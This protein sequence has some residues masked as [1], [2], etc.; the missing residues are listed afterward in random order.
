MTDVRVIPCLLLKNTG[1]VKTTRFADPVY[2]G[3]VINVVKLFNDMEADELGILDVTA[4]R[5]G[6][7]PSFGLLAKVA[8]NAFMP[9]SYGGG[10]ADL[11]DIHKILALGF[12][13]VII[14]SRAV[15]EPTLIDQAARAVGSQSVVVSIDVKRHLSAHYEVYSHGGKRRTR[16]NPVDFAGQAEQRGA[17]EILLTA[18]DRDGTMTGYDLDLIRAVSEAVTVPVIASGGAGHIRH[19]GEAARSGASAVAA[20]SLFVFHGP[21]RAVLIS[22]PTREQLE[23]VL[24]LPPAAPAPG[25]KGCRDD[26]ADC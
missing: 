22:F 13:K 16:T 26:A 18:I 8:A 17:G 23:R 20:A 6:R 12:E 1:L 24:A 11:E 21:R 5:E 15:D 19:F 14:G 9:L 4:T 2:L 25:G 7:R 10:V 3:D